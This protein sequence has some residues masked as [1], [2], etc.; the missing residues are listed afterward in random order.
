MCST[1]QCS[2]VMCQLRGMMRAEPFPVVVF[3]STTAIIGDGGIHLLPLSMPHIPALSRHPHLPVSAGLEEAVEDGWDDEDDYAGGSP[4]S[5]GAGARAAAGGAAAGGAGR[6]TLGAGA[7][8]AVASAGA[9]AAAARPAARMS[10]GKPSAPRVSLPAAAAAAAAAPVPAAAAGGAGGRG[11]E[12]D[13][14]DDSGG[15]TP[16]SDEEAAPAAGP[17]K[18]LGPV[19][20]GAHHDEKGALPAGWT[21]QMDDADRWYYNESTGVT[22]CE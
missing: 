4:A 13:W 18:G 1:A 21:I 22:S 19:V 10:V 15:G 5:A 8:K 9:T 17:A 16:S 3:P 2:D 14:G 12:D 11:A 7:A 6:A 20:S